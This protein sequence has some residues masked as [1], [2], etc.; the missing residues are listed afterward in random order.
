MQLA[1]KIALDQQF[2]DAALGNLQR[3][4]GPVRQDQGVFSTAVPA[5]VGDA[6]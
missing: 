1:R 4:F 2:V 5:A 6:F 3:L